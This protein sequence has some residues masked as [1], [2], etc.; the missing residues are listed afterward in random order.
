MGEATQA[1]READAVT[2]IRPEGV[3]CP[4]CDHAHEVYVLHSHNNFG[5]TRDTAGAM[6][7][8]NVEV[9]LRSI[10]AFE[11]DEEA[12]LSTFDPA[13]EWHPIE[14]GHSPARGHEAAVRVRRRWLENWEGHQIDVE[15]TKD[16][17]DSVVASSH[18]TGRGKRSGVEVDL[19]I[20]MYFKLRDGKI[21]YLYEYADRAEALEAAGLRE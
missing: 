18:I 3:T 19:R 17:A 5:G 2:M 20:Y 11:H 21:V 7:Q 10:E 8:E 9:V 14:E 15:E 1:Q 4:E 12:W 6:S 16:G 13:F